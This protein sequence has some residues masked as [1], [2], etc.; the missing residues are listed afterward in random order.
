MVTLTRRF[1]ALLGLFALLSPGVFA[2][3]VSVEEQVVE[4]RLITEWGTFDSLDL[5]WMAETSDSS[6]IYLGSTLSDLMADARSDESA[7]ATKGFLL[8]GTD[9]G[10]L[11]A[12]RMRSIVERYVSELGSVTSKTWREG[13]RPFLSFQ[14]A[15]GS[16]GSAAILAAGKGSVIVTGMGVKHSES[17]FRRLLESFKDEDTK[18]ALAKARGSRKI[19]RGKTPGEF[20]LNGISGNT[21]KVSQESVSWAPAPSNCPRG[22]CGRRW[23]WIWE[24]ARQL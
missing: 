14:L 11:D 5:H 7:P 17:D 19:A 12:K 9:A 1:L 2:D 18:E 21:K 24:P 23:L 8:V 20:T 6:L 13:S 15:D 3:P 4:G 22:S 10:D 16:S